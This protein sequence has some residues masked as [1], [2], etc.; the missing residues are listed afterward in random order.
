VQ[1]GR[2]DPGVL[3]SLPGKLERQPLLR[4]G[5]RGLIRGDPEEV[6]VEALGVADEAAPPLGARDRLRPPARGG[7]GDRVRS[8]AQ[9]PP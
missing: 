1:V 9:Q 3:K 6:G 2:D 7:F 8:V 5:R 4:V